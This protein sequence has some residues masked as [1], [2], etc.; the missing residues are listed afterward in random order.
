[1]KLVRV[2]SPDISG[3]VL[4]RRGTQYT[5]AVEFTPLDDSYVRVRSWNTPVDI[6][7]PPLGW[8][9]LTTMKL[10]KIPGRLLWKDM[11]SRGYW[12]WLGGKKSEACNV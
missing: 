8:V 9:L 4:V 7:W 11:R 1:M 12:I 5:H 3:H 2:Q 10:K 6:R